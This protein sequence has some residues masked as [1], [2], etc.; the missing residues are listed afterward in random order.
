MKIKTEAKVKQEPPERT[1]PSC[2]KLSEK[3][4]KN[5]I[6]KEI[7]ERPVGEKPARSEDDVV[8]DVDDDDD[9]EL[10]AR[11]VI[12]HGYEIGQVIMTGESGEE[13]TIQPLGKAQKR[14]VKMT[15][16]CPVK[17]G[18]LLAGKPCEDGTV[19]GVRSVMWHCSR[20]TVMSADNECVVVQRRRN[21]QG[22][23][24][25]PRHYIIRSLT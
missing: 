13:A 3:A 15:A 10:V 5:E 23:S 9:D 24:V 21:L 20:A 1:T 19:E 4:I 17:V 11:E 16:S 6:K 7:S 25:I 12:L 18:D 8:E 22:T 14:T 2:Q